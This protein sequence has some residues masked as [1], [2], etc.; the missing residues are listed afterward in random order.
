M[1]PQDHDH[2]LGELLSGDEISAFRRGS[3]EKSLDYVR[4]HRKRRQW[5]R[6]ATAGLCLVLFLSAGIV[7]NRLSEN[8]YSTQSRLTLRSTPETVSELKVIN[9]EELFRLFP[10]R[11]MALIGK[12]GEQEL[13]FL[14]GPFPEASEF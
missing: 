7:W 8:F 1:T 14:D 13:V 9:D 5:K 2:L 6:G 12:P 10:G 11:S 4:I 3:L